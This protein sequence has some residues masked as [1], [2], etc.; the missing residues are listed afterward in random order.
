MTVKCQGIKQVP[1]D[2]PFNTAVLF[3]GQN[4]IK[5]GFYVPKGTAKLSIEDNR[6]SLN[7][8]KVILKEPKRI[9]LLDIAGNPIGPNLTSDTFAGFDKMLFLHMA[10]CGLKH[11]ESGTFRSMKKLQHLDLFDNMLSHIEPGTF[12]GPSD[13][14]MNLFLHF[15]H[16]T[17]I[18]DGT[19]RRFSKLSDLRFS[20]NRLTS[21]PDL[22][23]LTE[24]VYLGLDSNQ[25][26]NISKLGNSK[27]KGVF[28]LDLNGNQI[29]QLPV[30]VFQ[31]LPVKFNLDM[32]FNKLMSV[33]DE[34]F[35]G[36][37]D[38]TQLML[39]F[40]SISQIRNRTFTGLKNLR[41]LMMIKNSLAFIP[42]NAFA[43][44]RLL[45]LLFLHGNEIK[46][47]DGNAFRGLSNLERLTL[48]GNP[49]GLLPVK[50]FDE[51]ASNVT[52]AISCRNLQ[53]L[54]PG[55]YTAFIECAPSASYHVL[56]YDDQYEFLDGLLGSGFICNGCR[57]IVE[58]YFRCSNCSFCM[59][60]T[61]SNLESSC[62]K[63]H[64]GGFYQDEM[65]QLE[66]KNCSIGT[67]VP[68]KDHPGKSATDCRACPYGT[69]S[70]ETAGYR[71]CRC[72]NNFYRF[73]RFG[74]CTACPDYGLNCDNDTAILA[75]NYYWKW[76][77][78][79][80]KNYTKF[81][82]NIHTFGPEYNKN[83]STF[84]GPLPKPLKCPYPESCKGG[85]DSACNV[86]YQGT[87][88]ATCSSNYYLRFNSCLQCPRM[89]ITII[90]CV[91]VILVFALLFVMVFWG[92]SRRAEDDRTRTVADVI[93]SCA[94]IVIGFY[95]VV[96]G[97]FSALLRVQW[98]I[99]LVS[100]E[101]YLKF[102]EGNILQFAPLSCIHPVLRLDPFLQFI[103]AIGINILVVFL[104][105]LYLFLRK[106]YINKMEIF[107][108]E[109]IKKISSLKKSCFRNIFLFL[110]LSYPMTTAAFAV[111]PVFFP[112]L[113][114]IPIYKYRESNPD[115]EEIAFGLRVFFENFKEKYWFWE[116]VEMY[117]KL[118]LISFILLFDSESRS[119]IGFAVIVASVSG[120]A[121]TIFRPI[122]DPFEDRLQTFVLWI[123][124]FNVC[125][126]AIYS[127]PNVSSSQ[128][129][130][131]S[132]FVNV[133]FVAINSAVL[134]L[135]VGKGLLYVRYNWKSLSSCPLRCFHL[136]C[137]RRCLEGR[138][139]GSNVVLIQ[140]TEE[141]L[142]L[143]S[144]SRNDFII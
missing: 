112:L 52:L 18:A 54:T 89:V 34:A 13:D 95:Q 16:L 44:N 138:R 120:I 107:E 114:L 21:V 58:P 53:T 84:Q 94:K 87:L 119:Q 2:L 127:Q 36:C 55:L 134:I 9:S 108:S 101:K 38:L 69:Q 31:N 123:I 62:L 60:G 19:F 59:T 23:G 136:I 142:L 12:E 45:Q 88:C 47:I 67:Y 86:G 8:L 137:P 79:A 66:C 73:D 15:N 140:P 41:V 10:R 71:A 82:E 28:Q 100:M 35:S 93:M 72:L 118:I 97:I 144:R 17:T 103:L 26:K 104:I 90:S 102:V 125:L 70:N 141:Q 133:I 126:G 77:N 81:V 130:N 105:L 7:N 106:R 139:T 48:F 128:G 111:Y 113:L 109:K 33:P 27:I 117:R 6:L 85:I 132:T 11:I 32:S 131:N 124:F 43:D 57:T 1:R 40:N 129:E 4:S 122:K 98:P 5:G 74:P 14:L 63:C 92:D 29:E 76:K 91:V 143:R 99:I 56:L 30:N 68:E 78:Q 50:I 115:E 46:Y 37:K 20:N 51:I 39:S 116:I 61:Y 24:V 64:A 80:M 121:Y 96:A 75:P 110:L 3:L 65:G 42:E 25:I 135:A 83:F 49:F 22:T